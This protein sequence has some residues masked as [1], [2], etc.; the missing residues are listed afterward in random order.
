MD[1]LKEIKLPPLFV[2]HVTIKTYKRTENKEHQ[3]CIP[4]TD[5]FRLPDQEFYAKL[6]SWSLSRCFATDDKINRMW[7]PARVEGK[8]ENPSLK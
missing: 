8:K 3:N 5:T 1:V 6:L 2:F 4:E 7:K